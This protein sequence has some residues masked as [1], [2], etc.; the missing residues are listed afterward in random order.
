MVQLFGAAYDEVK[1]GM[2]SALEGETSR[3]DRVDLV[4]VA[5]PN[6]TH[7]EITKAFL[8]AGFHVLCEKPMTITVEEGEEIVNLARETGKICAVNYGYTGYAL[9]R[10]MRALVARGDLGHLA[11][12]M[13][14]SGASIAAAMLLKELSAANRR[15]D[16]FVRELHH[17][18]TRYFDGE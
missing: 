13:W 9:V 10:H 18:N 8:K 7:F 3:P 2:R 15:F 17:F 6:A 4:T 1:K 12:M 11:L 16:A 14:A 5:T